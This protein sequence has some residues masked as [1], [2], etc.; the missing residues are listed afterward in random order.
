M[1][2]IEYEKP[3]NDA[4]LEPENHYSVLQAIVKIGGEFRILGENAVYYASLV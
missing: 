4:D 3:P 2:T 1:E